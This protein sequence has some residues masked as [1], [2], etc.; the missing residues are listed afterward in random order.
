MDITLTNKEIIERGFMQALNLLSNDYDLPI[1]LSWR[2]KDVCNYIERR[3]KK[4]NDMQKELF[5]KYGAN[6]EGDQIFFDKENPMPEDCL[7]QLEELN[8]IEGRIQLDS[9]LDLKIVNIK[10]SILI[11]LEKLLVKPESCLKELD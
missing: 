4:Y 6:K 5:I 10:P 7:K 9:L 3:I 1:A 8:N 2:I 11:T